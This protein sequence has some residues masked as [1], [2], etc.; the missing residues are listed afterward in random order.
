MNSGFY[1]FSLQS[2]MKFDV[3]VHKGLYAQSI[4]QVARSCFKEILRA[5]HHYLC[6]FTNQMLAQLDLL[7]YLLAE[8]ARCESGVIAPSHTQ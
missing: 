7:R 3:Y 8:T 4:Y 2:N 1:D 6:S 5:R